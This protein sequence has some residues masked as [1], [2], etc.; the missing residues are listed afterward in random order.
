MKTERGR[1][2]KR[3]YSR[4]RDKTELAAALRRMAEL[5]Q[6][7]D[8]ESSLTQANRLLSNSALPRHQRGRVLSLVAD[9]EF[10]RGAFDS[11]AGIYQRAAALCLDDPRLWVRPLVGQI[12]SYIKMVR[13]D[14]ALM[15]ARHAHEV[16]VR[17][18]A[19]FDARVSRANA[20]L[21]RHGELTVPVRPPRVSDVAT[22]L[23]FLFLQEGEIAIAKEFFEKAVQASSR[24]ACRARH[25][26]AR[27]ALA[28]GEPARAII[29]ASDCIYRGRYSAKTLSAWATLIAARRKLGGWQIRENLLRGLDRVEPSMRARA[30]LSIVTELRKNDMRQW[31]PLAESWLNREG[32]RFPIIATEIQKMLLA[33]AR[34]VAGDANHGKVAERLLRMPKLSPNEWLAAAKVGMEIRLRGKAHAHEEEL[35]RQAT[36][37]YGASFT[38]RAIH[39]LALSCQEASRPDLARALLTRNIRA[40]KPGPGIWSRSAW[41]LAR[42]EAAT[43]N[44]AIAADLFERVADTDAVPLR[45]R[46]QARLLGAQQWIAAGDE[47]ALLKARPKIEEALQSATEPTIAMDF[48]RQLSVAA[49]AAMREWARDMFDAAS[50]RARADFM[51]AQH[52]AIASDLLFRLA[53]RQVNDFGESAEVVRFWE[54]LGAE[55]IDWLW[56]ER[57][58]FWAYLG[59]VLEAYSLVGSHASVDEFASEWLHDPATPPVGRVH[60]GIP[61]GRWLIAHRRASEAMS[62]FDRL[63]VESPT[64]GLCVVAWY[65]KALLAYRQGDRAACEQCVQRLRWARGTKSLAP[66]DGDLLGK[67]LLLSVGRD[68]TRAL[69]CDEKY[70]QWI[71]E[72]FNRRITNDLSLLS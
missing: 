56:S 12:R 41:A 59:V 49:P 15:I 9:S 50:K 48:A 60:V 5:L 19:D 1:F 46:L 37:N 42:L 36:R 43:G 3:V 20:D 2:R 64:H 47:N 35:I 25:G 22:R 39:S 61:Y 13:P 66:R 58:Q 55:K 71:W 54:G 45:F 28:M 23:G 27:V 44:P 67:A 14:A 51:A 31:R 6:Q 17:K 68:I 32:S 69:E 52:P 65:W 53:R 29:L 21:A 26:L 63:V 70:P 38:P 24:R 34:H 40:L 57:E 72:N 30:T 18:F 11:A 7:R 10:K 8:F 33:S 62:L 4:P 16:A